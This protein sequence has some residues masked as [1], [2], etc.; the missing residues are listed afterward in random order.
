MTREHDIRGDP[1]AP[2]GFGSGCDDKRQSV[3]HEDVQDVEE[4]RYTT[5][6]IKKGSKARRPGMLGGTIEN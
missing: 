3:D 4:E 1:K 6:H 5:I 2:R